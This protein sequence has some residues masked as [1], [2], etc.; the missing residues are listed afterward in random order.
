M[1]HCCYIWKII[2]LVYTINL[3]KTCIIY[4]CMKNEQY[5]DKLC[6]IMVEPESVLPMADYISSDSWAVTQVS[7]T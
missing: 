2:S 5:I 3:S 4:L 1:L 6:R 7:V